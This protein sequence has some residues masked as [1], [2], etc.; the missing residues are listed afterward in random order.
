[1]YLTKKTEKD[2]KLL[3]ES[4][5]WSL[6]KMSE[7]KIYTEKTLSTECFDALV[8]RLYSLAVQSFKGTVA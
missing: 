7:L 3:I 5:C 6:S 4:S 1:M 2:T 8:M